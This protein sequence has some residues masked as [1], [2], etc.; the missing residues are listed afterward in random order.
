[1]AQ[2]DAI[3]FDS[4]DPRIKITHAR[5]APVNQF[6]PNFLFKKYLYY[7]EQPQSEEHLGPTSGVRA[8]SQ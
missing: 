6:D 2:P 7:T 1:M 4:G 5:S 8:S 3:A